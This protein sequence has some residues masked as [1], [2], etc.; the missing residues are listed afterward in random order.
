MLN[1]T[2]LLQLWISWTPG[3]GKFFH[4]HHTVLIWHHR[5]SI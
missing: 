2:V 1:L 4:I 5:T 3:A